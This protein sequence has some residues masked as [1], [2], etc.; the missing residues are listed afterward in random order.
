MPWNTPTSPWAM[1]AAWRPLATPSPVASTPISATSA[2]GTKAA[3]MP[4]AF[5]PPPT[6]ATTASGRRPMRARICAR[7]SSPITRCSSRT[8]SG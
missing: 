8:I 3:K 5:E 7:A 4:I 2:S 6:Q 1:V